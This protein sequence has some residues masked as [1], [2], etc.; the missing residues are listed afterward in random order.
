M[1]IT[2]YNLQVHKIANFTPQVGPNDSIYRRWLFNEN[3]TTFSIPFSNRLVRLCQIEVE[4]ASRIFMIMTLSRF[5]LSKPEGTCHTGC[6]MI[7]A[8]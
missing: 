2:F 7:K 3:E 4:S 5:F 6:R 8:L 1:A